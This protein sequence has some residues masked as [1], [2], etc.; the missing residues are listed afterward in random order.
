MSDTLVHDRR[1]THAETVYRPGER[2]L[3]KRL[4]ELLG[5]RVVDRGGH[6]FTAFVDPG[7]A[8]WTTNTIYASEVT[9]EQW[10][11]ERALAAAAETDEALGRARG[12]WLG[13]L[14]A[15]PQYSFHFG[16]RVTTDEAFDELVERVRHA[17]DHDAELAG[18]I[19]L[20]GVFRPGD[21][22]AATDTMLQAFV[23]TD[24]I[25]SGLVTLGQHIE[26]QR[27]LV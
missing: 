1:I 21:P 27:H 8:S 6:F 16:F 4:L 3:A 20:S 2:E 9:A 22:D 23:R 13:D 12:R 5:C 17:Q 14:A 11:F 10:A 18:R 26:I 15:R 19:R 24:V 25:A 7:V